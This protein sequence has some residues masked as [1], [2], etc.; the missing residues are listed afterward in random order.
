MGSHS[1]WV[2]GLR[3]ASSRSVANPS[4]RTRNLSANEW[5][6]T[7]ST[8]DSQLLHVVSG[9]AD[10]PERRSTLARGGVLPDITAGLMFAIVVNGVIGISVPPLVRKSGRRFVNVGLR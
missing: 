8:G 4:S 10:T 9:G 2:I 1:N 5:E 3:H 7:G 6:S